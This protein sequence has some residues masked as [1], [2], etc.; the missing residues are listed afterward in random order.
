M[1]GQAR[2]LQMTA[3]C[4][5][6]AIITARACP[7]PP[8]LLAAQLSDVPGPHGVGPGGQQLWLDRRRVA[9]LAAPL[10]HLTLA[11]QD[12]VHGGGRRQV[13]ALV[14]QLGIDGGGRLVDVFGLV[15]DPEH[16]LA[17]D[18]AEG[19]RL[20]GR[21]PLALGWRRALAVL[22]VVAGPRPT[23]RRTRRPGA[24]DRGQLVD[25]LVGH[26]C[27]PPVVVGGALSVASCS[28]S[29]ESFPW[30]SITLRALPSSPS[31]WATRRRSRA[32]SRSTGSTGGLPDGVPSTWS[33]PRSRCLRHSEMSEVYRPSRRNSEPLAALSRRSYSARIS[34]L[35]RAE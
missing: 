5:T 23:H 9:G 8:R 35:Y 28:N 24:N 4:E 19:P 2:D 18:L 25:G 21:H 17:L 26:C 27:S 34:A 32:F 29:A 14:E 16:L 1:A 6:S 22:P 12:A 7:A 10:G 13:D 15:Q 11:A 30:T 31:S 20:T 3:G 33:A